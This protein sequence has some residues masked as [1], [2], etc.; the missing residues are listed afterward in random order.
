MNTFKSIYVSV[1]FVFSEWKVTNGELQMKKSHHITCELN[2]REIISVIFGWFLSYY[3]S[4]CQNVSN[5]SEIIRLWYWYK[6]L[7]WEKESH[8][9]Y[10][11]IR[12]YKNKNTSL[13]GL[14]A[15]MHYVLPANLQLVL[16]CKPGHTTPLVKLL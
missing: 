2:C 10:W 3:R 7:F 4:M 5:M 12:R 13:L 11:K 9:K 16:Q 8:N 1:S 15:S 6:I 14:F